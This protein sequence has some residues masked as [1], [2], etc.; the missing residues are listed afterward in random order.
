MAE[1]TP[2]ILASYEQAAT[3]PRRPLP[4]TMTGRPARMGSSSTSTDAKNESMSTWRMTRWP[5]GPTAT[6]SRQ[7]RSPVSASPRSTTE[8]QPP[9]ALGERHTGLSSA[10]LG[11]QANCRGSP[12]HAIG[13]LTP[14]AADRFPLDVHHVRDVHP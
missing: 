4:P 3:T 6:G 11:A 1:W 10:I 9:E 12:F 13:E 2:N 8:A 5:P 7:P 14:M